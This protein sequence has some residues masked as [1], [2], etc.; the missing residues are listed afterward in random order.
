MRGGLLL[1]LLAAVAALGR[2]PAPAPRSITPS[3]AEPEVVAA[4]GP[5]VARGAVATVPALEHVGRT[6]LMSSRR[7]CVVGGRVLAP[8]GAAVPAAIVHA[9]R[10]GAGGT[11]TDEP[12]EE[13]GT[14]ETDEGGA[15]TIEL[16]PGDYALYAAG[17]GRAS[18]LVAPISLA[19]GEEVH[20]LELTL[21]SAAKLSGLVVDAAGD[22]VRG[23]LVTVRVPGD[24]GIVRTEGT[25]RAGA[26]ELDDLPDGPLAI[27]VL[28]FFGARARLE[29]ARPERDLVVR[30]GPALGELTIVVIDE[31][32]RPVPAAEL[33]IV[34]TRWAAFIQAG[35]DG[36]ATHAPREARL[37][38][39]ATAGEDRSERT[40][41]DLGV[42]PTTVRLVVAAGATVTGRVLD[43]DGTPAR[44][45]VKLDGERASDTRAEADLDEEGRYELLGLRP[46]RYV[47][48]YA[49]SERDAAEMAF[50]VNDRA[51]RTLPD[52][53]L[54]AERTLAGDVRDEAGALVA[55]ADVERIDP[56]D[57]STS[58]VAVTG[59]DGRFTASVRAD[60]PV[61][62]RAAAPDGTVSPTLLAEGAVSLVVREV[63]NVDGVVRGAPPGT[64][65]RCGGGPWHAVSGGQYSL[66]CPAGCELE[67][68]GGGT[69]RSFPVEV[70]AEDGAYVE[71]RW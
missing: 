15:F 9:T 57:G 34:G 65:V 41:I 16:G 27:D 54:A 38:L 66:Q 22:P 40:D 48:R 52:L 29:L 69:R 7:P 44:G 30:L 61:R 10:V 56:S 62:L 68:E 20:D 33:S 50:S 17:G 49:A 59:D 6:P 53:R 51:R 58:V 35:E 21:S 70:D 43:A 47:V 46:G 45:T 14:G 13:V 37:T 24:A 32:G 31:A 71:V 5:R 12:T 1:V 28:G 55:G 4:I 3:R 67:L 26:F 63:G 60:G 18:A 23:A 36:I 64:R 39:E 2:S 8:N 19:P 25:T 42:A 11:D